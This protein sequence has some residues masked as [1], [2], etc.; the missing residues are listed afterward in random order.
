MFGSTAAA[1]VVKVTADAKS[2]SAGVDGVT[3]KTSKM[4]R[5]GAAA[6][7]ALAAGLLLAA[8]AAISAASAAAED[9]AAQARL[10]TTM[11]NAAGATSSQIA[12]TEEWI[13]A[14]GRALGVSDDEL[15]PALGALVAATGDVEKAQRLA[16]L[17]MDVSAGSGK[18][19][20][21]V[22]KALVAAEKGR[23]A[24]LSK[25]GVDTKNAA[26]ETRSLAAI[27][28]DLAATYKGAASSAAD[29]VAGKQA[30]LKVAMGELQEEI[31]LKLLPVLLKLAT[32]GMTVVDW[33][34]QNQ[35]A[36]AA[37]IGTIGGLLAI[38][39]AVSKAMAAWTAIVK[40]ATALQAAYNIVMAAN[41]VVLIVLAFVALAAAVVIAYKRSET[42]RNIVNGA[43]AAIS[44]TVAGVVAFI[45]NHWKTMLAILAGP[46]G[47]AVLLIVKHKDAIIAAFVAAKGWVS[48]KWK[49]VK[50][51]FAN[52][53]TNAKTLMVNAVNDVKGKIGEVKTKVDEVGGLIS[54]GLSAAFKPIS[55]AI[56]WVQDLIDKI[57]NI[58]MPDLNPLN[59]RASAPVAVAGSVVDRTPRSSTTARTSTR[60]GDVYIR[61]DGMTA[62]AILR[63][64]RRH[65]V[66]TGQAVGS[67]AA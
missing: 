49:D 27:Q 47:L 54:A 65:G 22:T 33:I 57:A 31:G 35:T 8:G 20:E 60:G 58:K 2:A 37:I 46:V 56:G 53:I 51:L 4:G 18:S 7:K 1:L 13:A 16:A 25:F 61:V 50:D 19:V 9:Q 26:G 63:L 42:F 52:P 10:A 55:T 12:A 15:R 21:A 28:K 67:A 14:Q 64:L 62:D 66:N 11:Q 3:T 38:T 29:T 43:F 39:F 6:G 34:T 45:K 32:V 23:S 30:R 17:A 41:P 40:V 44:K 59:G 48:D 24:G 36:A 5:V